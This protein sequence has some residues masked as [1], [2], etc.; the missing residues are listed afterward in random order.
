MQT[1]TLPIQVSGASAQPAAARGNAGSGADAATP[2]SQTLSQAHAQRSKEPARAPQAATPA[3]PAVPPKPANAERASPAKPAEPAKAAETAPGAK[4]DGPDATTAAQADADAAAAA[5]AAATAAAAAG[6]PAEM[7]VADML[8]LVASFLPEKAASVVKDTPA[9]ET[10]AIRAARAADLVPATRA[11][12]MVDTAAAPFDAARAAGTVETAAAPFA[13]ALADSAAAVAADAQ[14][15]DAAAVAL[16]ALAQAQPEGMGRGRGVTENLAPKAAPVTA[17]AAASEGIARSDGAPKDSGIGALPVERSASA[18]ALADQPAAET[19]IQANGAAQQPAVRAQP[20]AAIAARPAAPAAFENTVRDMA[21]APVSA[22]VQQASLNIA[23]AAAGVHTDKIAAR[24]GTPGWDNQV[25][26]KIVWMVAGKEQSATLTLNPPDLGPMQ[27]VLSVTND[28]ASVTFSSAQ[29][30]V[31]AALEN[32][33]PR[34]R[35]MLDESGVALSNAS[36]NAG[37]PD[38]RQAQGEPGRAG[39][40]GNGGGLGRSETNGSATAAAAR[41]A[42]RPGGGNGLVDTFA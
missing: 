4:S 10:I 41:S 19:R 9:A 35:E 21:S 1:P 34:L 39:N 18:A 2:F 37:M 3:T 11:A 7:P 28:Q 16:P 33:L 32:A 24:V 6:A 14:P 8:A 27:V 23:Q 26:Q 20:E 38:Q 40:N 5:A 22:P 31:R 29:P 42:A 25:G 12:D 17:N 13:A 30:E 15:A 36:V